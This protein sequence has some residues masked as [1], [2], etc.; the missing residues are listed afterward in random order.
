MFGTRENDNWET[1][2]E[3]YED[4]RDLIVGKIIWDPFYSQGRAAAFLMEAGAKEVIH[5]ER[6]AFDWSPEYELI[7]TNPPFSIKKR[8]LTYLLSLGK[9]VLILL[10]LA[11]L[12]SVWFREVVEE[13]QYHLYVP[14]KRYAFLKDGKQMKGVSFPSVW[15]WFPAAIGLPG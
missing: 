7:V 15:F 13:H 6:D 12:A 11:D 5:E 1:P 3:A 14:K 2:K 10:P 4:V 9:P 8:C